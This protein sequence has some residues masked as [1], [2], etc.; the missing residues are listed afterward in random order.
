MKG[1][2]GEGRRGKGEIGAKFPSHTKISEFLVVY[3]RGVQGSNA[4]FSNKSY[5]PE[6]LQMY[7]H[8]SNLESSEVWLYDIDSLLPITMAVSS[9]K[10]SW[11]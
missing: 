8:A 6:T 2:L 9:V 5:N 4:D 1:R 3:I 7:S 11:S 10:S